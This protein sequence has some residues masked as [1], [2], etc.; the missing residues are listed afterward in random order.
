MEKSIDKKCQFPEI[1]EEFIDTCESVNGECN[2]C[3]FFQFGKYSEGKY[4][5]DN[6]NKICEKCGSENIIDPI[7]DDCDNGMCNDCGFHW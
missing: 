1:N 4:I 2:N 7:S 5:N 6:E 3:R